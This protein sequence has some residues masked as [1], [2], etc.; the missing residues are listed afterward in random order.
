VDVTLQFTESYRGVSTDKSISKFLKSGSL[1]EHDP[2]VPNSI[3]QTNI[4]GNSEKATS[5][6][7]Y[8]LNIHL[9]TITALKCIIKIS[10]T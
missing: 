10:D 7:S 1:V 5:K 4:K 9:S 8:V 2:L 3:H 6:E